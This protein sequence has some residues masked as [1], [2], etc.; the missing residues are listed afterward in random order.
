[1]T[2]WRLDSGVTLNIGG[3]IYNLDGATRAQRNAQAGVHR[4]GI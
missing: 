1:M 3:G 2:R 4:A